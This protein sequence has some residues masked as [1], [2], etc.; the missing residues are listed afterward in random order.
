MPP[1]ALRHLSQ[2][3][4]NGLVISDRR[5]P[6]ARRYRG[7]IWMME[8]QVS[9]EAKCGS[10]CSRARRA[11]AKGMPPVFVTEVGSWG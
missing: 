2:C 1:I 7:D 9:M 5:A 3:R 8:R 4:L 6:D 10:G 11:P